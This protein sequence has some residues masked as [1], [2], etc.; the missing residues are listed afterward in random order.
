MTV[1]SSIA[2]TSLRFTRSHLT[3]FSYF[4]IGIYAY[5]INILGP[6]IPF[7][8]GEMGFSYTVSSLH[9]SAFAIGM[10][11]AGATGDRIASRMGRRRA[12]WLGAV[13]LVTG[14]LLLMV[15]WNPIVTI[16]SAL[17]MGTVGTLLMVT[18]N[19]SLADQYGEQRTVAFTESNVI[20]GIY[21]I[22]APLLLGFASRTIF[23]WR[24]T[25]A[26]AIIYTFWLYWRYQN[27]DLTTTATAQT[28]TAQTATI[29]NQS[30]QTRSNKLPAGYWRYWV[31]LIPL[32]AVEFCITGWAS[33]FLEVHAGMSRANAA[34]MLSL[35][36]L[37]MLLGRWFAT[38]AM[39]WIAASHL[40]LLAIGLCGAGFLLHWLASTALLSVTG[41]FLAGLGVAN[42]FPLTMGLAV[43]AAA[44]QA[45]KASA[46]IVIASGSAILT[47][48][49][50][51]GGLADW[52]GL[53]YAYPIVLPL[54]MVAAWLVYQE[55]TAMR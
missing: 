22:S 26:I 46:R 40:L 54:L 24:A 16:A 28:V 36:F 51:L 29:Q 55:I 18:V 3:W 19:A 42:H 45:D 38:V 20:A 12:L 7:L 30:G 4:S 11:I 32:V 39:R 53:W 5:L 33:T 23:G 17:L 21:T 6:I 9:T 2:S 13:G 31:V 1:T 44:D 14:S 25:L 27:F 48:P 52:A 37:A 8:R 43:G 34:L 41:L 49:L 15:G 10:M 35:F 47:L 50:L